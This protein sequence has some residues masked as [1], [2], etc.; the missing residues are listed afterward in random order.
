[1]ENIAEKNKLYVERIA[2]M[3]CKKHNETGGNNFE[4]LIRY[5]NNSDNIEHQVA[6]FFINSNGN[7]I[8]TVG[9]MFDFD[10][11]SLREV[12]DYWFMDGVLELLDKYK[13][14][15]NLEF[16]FDEDDDEEYSPRA[17]I[18]MYNPQYDIEK[19]NVGDYMYIDGPT[20]FCQ[21]SYNKIVGKHTRYDEMTGK[22]YIIFEDKE[23]DTYDSRTGSCINNPNSMYSVYHYGYLVED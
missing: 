20:S 19:I 7:I 12:V 18:E 2:E 11:F 16:L 6:N 10:F 22:P 1:M 15:V 21:G 8:G 23:G 13:E 14:E 9:S 3:I 5:K 17:Y 4:V